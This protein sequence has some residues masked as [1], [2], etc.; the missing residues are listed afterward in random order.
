M[1]S[2]K[3]GAFLIRN[4]DFPMSGLYCLTKSKI[5]FCTTS[6]RCV[7]TPMCGFVSLRR[8]L[9]SVNATTLGWGYVSQSVP[10]EG[11]IDT[12]DDL[13]TTAEAVVRIEDTYTEYRTS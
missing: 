3:T 1:Y 9:C 6:V 10:Q 11:L 7:D 8:S 5:I 12:I 4:I 2:W 13:K